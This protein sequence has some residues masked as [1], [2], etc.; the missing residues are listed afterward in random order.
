VPNAS[1]PC[2]HSSVKKLNVKGFIKPKQKHNIEVKVEC[3]MQNE[4]IDA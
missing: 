3:A 1:N 4:R 2:P